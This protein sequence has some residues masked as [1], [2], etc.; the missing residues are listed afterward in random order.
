MPDT[1]QP[2]RSNPFPHLGTLRIAGRLLKQRVPEAQGRIETLDRPPIRKLRGFITGYL[3]RFNSQWSSEGGLV[4]I[5]GEHGS[6][7]THTIYSVWQKLPRDERLF[8]IYVLQQNDD[9]VALYREVTGRM[10]F[11]LLKQLSRSFLGLMVARE[12]GENLSDEKEKHQIEQ[13]LKASPDGARETVAGNSGSASRQDAGDAVA[14]E[15]PAAPTVDELFQSYRVEEGAATSRQE[16]ALRDMTQGNANLE[17]AVRH[18]QGTQ[19]DQQAADWLL[20][21][22]VKPEDLR[23]MAIS[24]PIDTPNAAAAALELLAALFS[25]GNRALVLFI[26]QYEKLLTGE[27]PI[28]AANNVGWIRSVGEAFVAR[29]AMLVLSGN[30]EAWSKLPPDLSQRVELSQVRCTVFTEQEGVDILRLYLTPA[31]IPFHTGGNDHLAPFTEDGVRAMLEVVGGN[32][33]RLLQL[34]RAAY[35]STV[36]GQAID[37]QFIRRMAREET[38]FDDRA[39]V[40]QAVEK[41]MVRQPFRLA[42]RFPIQDM[43]FDFALLDSQGRPALLVDV[44]SAIFRD[45]EAVNAMITAGALARLRDSGS[46]AAYGLVATGYVSPEIVNTL[47][48]V[49]TRLIVY[50]RSTFESEMTELM[51]NV[52]KI[53]PSQTPPQDDA[54]RQLVEIRE[55]I[56]KIGESRAKETVVVQ[57]RGEDLSSV[58]EYQRY[59]E[60]RDQARKDWSDMRRKLEAEI[61]RI[62]K[63][64]TEA[65]LAELERLRKRAEVVHFWRDVLFL[66]GAAVALGVGIGFSSVS[67]AESGK[68]AAVGWGAAIIYFA[69]IVYDRMA[70]WMWPHIPSRV[71]SMAQLEQLADMRLPL[72]VARLMELQPNP[73]CRFV[74]RVKQI[75]VGHL[76]PNDILQIILA[77][78][79]SVLRE[80]LCRVV[81]RHSPAEEVKN[82]ELDR[83]MLRSNPELLLLLEHPVLAE[84][85]EAGPPEDLIRALVTGYPRG[86]ERFSLYLAAEVGRPGSDGFVRQAFDMGLDRVRLGK[87]RVSERELREAVREWSPFEEGGLGTH[88]SLFNIKLVDQVFLFVSQLQL[89][90]ERD[91]LDEPII[92]GPGRE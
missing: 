64:R 48:R 33:R 26:D 89:Y 80:A 42:K 91:L 18:L 38:E 11:P 37:G 87:F 44:R 39:L 66:A 46:Q 57:Q 2:G 76:H 81:V 55:L 83:R 62:H 58:H 36:P 35:E 79:V 25:I 49:V 70:G 73:L 92:R 90:F 30:E 50:K 14:T 32:P 65:R 84:Q 8:P 31:D 52:P 86:P 68:I 53:A 60:R 15:A 22:P 29:N 88:D 21:K 51:V 67:T 40:E 74:R 75:S 19:F 72:I 56:A 71:T 54:S 27:D 1:A 63:E 13:Q 45:D 9:F 59:E 85:A 20:A 24:R 28:L 16:R 82:W 10:D 17:H 69:A 12:L 5:R 41:Y 77:E 6:G 23:A 43:T 61:P 7:K 47:A 34:A 78:P 3:A 4:V